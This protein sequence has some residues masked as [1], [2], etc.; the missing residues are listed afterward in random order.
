MYGRDTFL[1]R[2][3]DDGVAPR[4]VAGDYVYVDP[5]E[6]AEH[7]RLVAVWDGEPRETAV[8]LYVVEDGRRVLR[9]LAGGH[10]D[11]VVDADN[12]TDIRGVVVFRG[13][14]V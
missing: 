8:R 9:A 6:P 5:D 3:A 11:R 2:V 4:L 1:V 10:P 12:E 7:G 14:K 13:R